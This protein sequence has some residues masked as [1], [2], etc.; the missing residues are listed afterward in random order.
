MTRNERRAHDLA[1]QIGL[2]ALLR[3]LIASL[4]PAN[5]DEMKAFIRAL[6][7]KAVTSVEENVPFPDANEATNTFIREAA[8]GYITRIL[9]SIQHP[10][11]RQ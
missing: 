11:D 6:E 3:A 4:A 1:Q 8:S 10:S 9:A 7:E 2:M 5:R